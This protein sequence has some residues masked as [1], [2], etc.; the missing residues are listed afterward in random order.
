MQSA[1]IPFNQLEGDPRNIRVQYTGIDELAYS[2]LTYGLL[3]RL[4][5]VRVGNKFVVRDGNRRLRALERLIKS[6]HRTAVDGVDCLILDSDGSFEQVI[7]EVQKQEAPIWHLGYRFIEFIEAGASQEQ[8]GT[9]IGRSRGYVSRAVNIAANLAPETI[10][11]LDSIPIGTLSAE[12]V[13]RIS[14][15]INPVTKKPD[16]KAQLD[17]I[18]QFLDLPRAQRRSGER[19]KDKNNQISFRFYKLKGKLRIPAEHAKVVQGIIDYLD[20]T[21]TRLKLP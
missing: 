16:T 21:T 8:I 19:K 7:A 13:C 3:Q 9:S 1:T 14:T 2:I 18:T 4:L 20:G 10:K 6:G 11:R 12:Q 15:L 17:K 5:V